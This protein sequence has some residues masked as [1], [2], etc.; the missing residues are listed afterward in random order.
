M[1]ITNTLAYHCFFITMTQ[2]KHRVGLPRGEYLT[3][4]SSKGG[5]LMTGIGWHYTHGTGWLNRENVWYED[6]LHWP[7]ILDD[8]AR[9]WILFC[10]DHISHLV[11]PAIWHWV[12]ETRLELGC[13]FGA[14][15]DPPS[16]PGGSHCLPMPGNWPIC[17]PTFMASWIQQCFISHLGKPATI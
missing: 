6:I 3:N 4:E 13:I 1:V 7:D 10:I 12:H 2:C 11:K 14:H 9:W 16:K 8:D 17:I 5:P 15:L